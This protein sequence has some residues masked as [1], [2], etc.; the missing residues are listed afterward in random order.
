[1]AR[2]ICQY[3][4]V[5]D[6]SAHETAKYSVSLVLRCDATGPDPMVYI[7][8]PGDYLTGQLDIFSKGD[9]IF[10]DIRVLLEGVTSKYFASTIA[11]SLTRHNKNMDQKSRS[12]L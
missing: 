5:D 11:D 8:H 9:V 3:P 6:Q 2:S 12:R 4:P 1:M 10:E 7:Y